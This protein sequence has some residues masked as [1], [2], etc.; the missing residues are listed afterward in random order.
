MSTKKRFDG[1]TAEHAMLLV[2]IGLSALFLI[3]PIVQDYPADARVFPQMMAGVVF[4]GCLLLLVQ[5]YLPGPLQTFVAEEMTVTATDDSML[6]GQ[7][8]TQE[9]PTEERT[10][11]LGE[12]YGYEVNDTLFMVVT[13]TAYLVAGWA[14]GFLFVTLP[15]VFA[16]TTWFRIPWKTGLALAVSATA[17][18]WFFMEFLILPFDRGAIFDFS[19]FLP[20]VVEVLWFVSPELAEAAA[21]VRTRVI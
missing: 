12:E 3:E 18:V 11:R 5:N 16:Y 9:T 2:L 19:P 6:E 21:T 8:E 7:Q 20:F 15:F 14:A 13:S 17:I 1:V 4:V 10:P